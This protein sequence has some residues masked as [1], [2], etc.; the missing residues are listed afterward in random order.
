MFESVTLEIS[1]KPFGKH[2]ESDEAAICEKMFRQWRALTE[3]RK[4]VS[5]LMWVSDGS[6]ILDYAGNPDD[7]FEWCKYIGTANKPAAADDDPP[8]LSPHNKKQLYVKEPAVFTYAKLK[9][10]VALIRAVGRKHCP[11]AEIRIGETFDIGPEFA[12][13][14]FKY[15]RHREI[16]GGS[17]IDEFGF[18]DSTSLLRADKRKYAAF[19]D[20]IKENTPFA[21]F[22]GRQA[23]VFLEDMGFDYIW[24]SNGLGFSADP[25]ITSGKIFDGENFH[26][27][28]LERTAKK[29]FDFWRLFREACP[30]VP[31][32]TR[33]T[34]NTVG[35]DY[36]SD[37]VPL[38][39]IYKSGFGITPPP[40]SPW[41]ALN[42]DF[43]LELAGQMTRVCELPGKDF[44]FRFYLHDPWWANSP[45]FDRYN[46]CP[47]DVYMPMAISRIDENGKTRGAGAFSILSVDNS[48]GDMPDEY[49]NESLPH[50]LKAEK[51]TPDRPAPF[52]WVYP[53]KEFTAASDENLLR[54]M[55][56]G[57]KFIRDAIN[58]GF[59]LNCVVSSS[60]FLKTPRSVYDGCVMVSPVQP[61]DKVREK[62]SAFAAEGRLIC[63]ADKPEENAGLIPGVKNGAF[64]QA[65]AG[66]AGKMLEAARLTGY[67]IDFSKLDPD[68]PPPVM[69]V[70]RN[71]NAFIFSVM[72]PDTT[73]ET[74]ISFP[75]GAPVFDC[76]EAQMSEGA[77]IYRFPRWMHGECRVFV[78]QKSGVVS[79]RESAPVN[80]F[81]RRVVMIRGLEN[82]DVCL[83]PET[84]K[85][86]LC[87]I[88]DDVRK[89]PDG[90]PRFLDSFRMEKNE[91]GICWK[92][93]NVS[94][95]LRL[96]MPF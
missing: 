93:E 84:H 58:A 89:T 22:F 68:T 13:S 4:V 7:S 53:M 14:D 16:T 75:L 12:V 47:H 81:F 41:A 9:R 72:N 85:A 59:P 61:D 6:E 69:T 94:G 46:S 50:F 74:K 90:L 27:E 8:Y 2:G 34:N 19:P 17:G 35:I 62:L 38:W 73:T 37:G 40:N 39:D 95:G 86:E 30:D 24:L 60:S 32:E 51:H 77:A 43:G 76:W 18:V 91:Y 49:V 33:G 66:G 15:K 23:K 52:V 20:G 3:N 80:T 1:L 10:L 65:C 28:K 11:G 87:R 67:T 82:A 29:V 88:A 79:V 96:M 48:F 31:I 45:W 57:D 78:R 64:V 26:P 70:H 42:D 5:V 56:F 25:W 21:S 83:F 54:E 55:Y 44:M 92:A 36:A 71:D 63:Y